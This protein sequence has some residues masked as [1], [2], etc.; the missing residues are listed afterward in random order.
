MLQ[1]RSSLVRALFERIALAVFPPTYVMNQ[2]MHIHHHFQDKEE[3]STEQI[4]IRFCFLTIFLA[5]V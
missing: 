4:R 2:L 3:E 1:L 5:E